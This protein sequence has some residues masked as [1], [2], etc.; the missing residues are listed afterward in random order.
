MLKKLWNDPVWSKVIAAAII[1][2]AGGAWLAHWQNWWTPIEHATRVALGTSW[3]FLTG[4]TPVRRWIYSLLLVVAGLFVLLLVGLASTLYSTKESVS[5][6]VPIVRVEDWRS[7]VTDTFYEIKW[8]WGYAGGEI[9][10]M[11]AFCPRCDYQ[12]VPEGMSLISQISFR[13]DV[14]GR[15]YDIQESWDSVRSI[16]KRLVQQKL[17]SETYPKQQGSERKDG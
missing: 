15:R 6:F 8:R 16:V 5:P 11:L 1:A 7:Y 17:R 9:T 12:M 4:T 14:C 13:C 10:H 2:L 3:M